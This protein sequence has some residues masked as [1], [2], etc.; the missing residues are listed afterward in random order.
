MA[1]GSFLKALTSLFAQA[2]TKVVAG[3]AGAVLGYFFP[4]SATRDMFVVSGI[5][6]LMDTIT[7]TIAAWQTGEAMQSRRFA[8]VLAKAMVYSCVAGAVSISLRVLPGTLS[9]QDE[10]VTAILGLVIVTELI[11]II[12]NADK[13]NLKVVPPWLRNLV[14]DTEKRLASKDAKE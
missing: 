3:A 9:L 8:R 14:R 7:G 10:G 2:Q 11:S 6:L 1:L 5:L 4:S 12:E 13:M